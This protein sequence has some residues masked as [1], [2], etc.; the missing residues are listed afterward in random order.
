[1]G[2]PVVDATRTGPDR[3]DPLGSDPLLW[4]LFPALATGVEWDLR[5]TERALA[6]LGDPHRTF[7]S[8]HVGGTNGKGSVTATLASV[9]ERA[10]HSVGAYTSP[11]LRSFLERILVD[12]RPVPQERLVAYADETREHITRERLTFFEAATVLAFH[13][14]AREGVRVAAVEVGLG[15]RLDATNVLVPEVCGV[16]NIAM[17]HAD[18]LGDTLAD[19]AREKAGIAKRGVPFVTTETDPA[20]LD[21]LG[22]VAASVGA[23]FHV[24]REDDVRDVRVR[25]DGTTFRMRTDAWGDLELAT[26]L[27]GA[28]QARNAAVAVAMLDRLGDDLLPDAR[29]VREGVAEVRHHGR[30]ELRAIGGRTWLFDVAHNPAGIATLADTLD[31]LDL[32]RP[33]VALVGILADKDWRAMLP[34]LRA[35]TDAM[36]LGVPPSAP[37]DRRWS[38]GDVAAALGPGGPPVVAVEDFADAVAEASRRAG[39]GTVVVTGSVHTV[40]GAM[41]ALGVDPIPGG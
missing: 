31:W 4:R 2:S 30:N 27:V 28:H 23:P 8:L 29:A 36:V 6:A 3:L 9:M 24:V 10:G 1:V 16:T 21:V 5:R 13:A 12:G 18:Y 26:P 33:R 20:L 22:G 38:P 15:G 41:K 35:R 39:S 40:G 7:R 17:D 11:H 19:I 34:P 32:P 25:T 14:F 37:R